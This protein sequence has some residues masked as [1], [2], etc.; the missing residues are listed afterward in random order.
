MRNVR[1]QLAG[2]NWDSTLKLCES[3]VASRRRATADEHNFCGV[4]SILSATLNVI[5]LLIS[6]SLIV[7]IVGW[8]VRADS[9]D[10]SYVWMW[11]GISRLL[12][13][14]VRVRTKWACMRAHVMAEMQECNCMGTCAYGHLDTCGDAYVCSRI[15]E[16]QFLEVDSTNSGATALKQRSFSQFNLKR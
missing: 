7:V 15:F 3:A 5:L 8:L 4:P 11:F 10:D 16:L 9:L 1:T 14:R 2:R 6:L 12:R 13:N